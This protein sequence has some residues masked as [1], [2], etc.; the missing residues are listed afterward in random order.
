MTMALSNLTRAGILLFLLA[1]IP[2]LVLA[3]SNVTQ[4]ERDR[5]GPPD[6]ATIAK[7][8]S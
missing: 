1:V 4:A 6:F 7:N 8:C 3:V 2:L 5:R